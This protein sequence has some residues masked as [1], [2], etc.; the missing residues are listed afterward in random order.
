LIDK[1][2][3]IDL[4]RDLYAFRTGAIAGEN[5]SLFVWLAEEQLFEVFSF[6]SGDS[7]NRRP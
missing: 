2:N 1:S 7:F 4:V 6:H 3:M 5:E